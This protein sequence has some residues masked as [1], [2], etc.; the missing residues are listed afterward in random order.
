MVG[1]GGYRVGMG[2]RGGTE[3]IRWSGVGVI[4]WGWG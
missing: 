3:S 2:V 1:G 4:G